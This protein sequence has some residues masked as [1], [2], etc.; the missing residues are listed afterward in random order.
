MPAGLLYPAATSV[1]SRRRRPAG[2][3]AHVTRDARE[4]LWLVTATIGWALLALLA[5]PLVWLVF[6]LFFGFLYVLPLWAATFGVTV[7]ACVSAAMACW[8]ADRVSAPLVLGPLLLA[9]VA[10]LV[11]TRPFRVSRSRNRARGRPARRTGA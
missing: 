3:A 11:W 5:P 6:P 9:A 10:T 7:L 1:A 2:Y 4:Q 8:H